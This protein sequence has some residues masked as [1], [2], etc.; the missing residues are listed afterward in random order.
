MSLGS[1]LAVL[2]M[3]KLG[4]WSPWGRFLAMRAEYDAVVDRLIDAAERTELA[5]RND[6]LAMMLQTRYEDGAAM[7]RREIADQLLTLLAAGHETT[8]TTLAWAVERL[9]RHPAILRD[10]V[11]EVDADGKA[12]RE[13]TVLEVQRT[14]PVIDM[15]G[16]QVKADSF[17]LGRWTVPKGYAVLVSIALIHDDDA[18]F[19]NARTFDPSRF[20]GARP[21]LYHWIPFGGGSRRC[22]GAAFANMEMNVVLRTM[23]RDV[24]LAPTTEADERWHSR[25]IAYAP[26]KGGLAVVRRRVPRTAPATEAASGGVRP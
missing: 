5:D 3:P 1:R 11:D 20:V 12:L 18:V 7:S 2:P 13:A 21:D 19:P 15:V 4:R 22:L 25:G 6:V 17:E 8:A 26:G 16:R 23:L 9:R 24:T 10:L 14:R